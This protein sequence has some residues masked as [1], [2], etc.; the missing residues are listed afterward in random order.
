[1]RIDIQER[2]IEELDRILETKGDHSKKLR[3]HIAG[4]G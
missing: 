3:I 4:F 1:M 2:A